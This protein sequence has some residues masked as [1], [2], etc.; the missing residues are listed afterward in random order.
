MQ[1]GCR[2]FGDSSADVSVRF[3]LTGELASNNPLVPVNSIFAYS[4][5]KSSNLDDI[6]ARNAA[7]RQITVI[8][9]VERLDLGLEMNRL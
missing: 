4:R 9:P 6:P 7:Y 8:Q 5:R 2:N 3:S 1:E